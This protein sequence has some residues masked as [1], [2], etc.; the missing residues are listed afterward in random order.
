MRQPYLHRGQRTRVRV[1]GIGRNHCLT[2]SPGPDDD[3]PAYEGTT[4]R[5]RHRPLSSVGTRRWLRTCTTGADGWTVSR[6]MSDGR[7]WP[8][9]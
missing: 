2:V 6:S 4:H 1:A 9:R 3:V 8:G 7:R 5:N